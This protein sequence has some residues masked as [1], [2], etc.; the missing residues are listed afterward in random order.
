MRKCKLFLW[1]NLS[2]HPI[3]E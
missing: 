2:K 3:L 1:T